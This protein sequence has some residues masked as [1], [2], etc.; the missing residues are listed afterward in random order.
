MALFDHMRKH[1]QDLSPSQKKLADY[2]ME[3]SR[4]AVFLNVQTLAETLDVDPATVTR[5][6]QRLGYS[7][8]R[9]LL[10]EL[11][12]MIQVELG[13]PLERVEVSREVQAIVAHILDKELH[14]LKEA[15]SPTQME[16][17]E[18]VIH[19]LEGAKRIFVLAHGRDAGFAQVF[20]HVLT[21]ALGTP[22]H[23]VPSDVLHGMFG[24]HDLGPGDVVVGLCLGSAGGDTGA[25][26][27]LAKSQGAKS[28]ALVPSPASSLA[29]KAD[30]ALFCPT[31]SLTRASSFVALA[32]VL[33]ALFQ[34]LALRNWE[35]YSERGAQMLQT[36]NFLLAK[37][38]STTMAVD[39][40]VPPKGNPV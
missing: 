19:S 13:L 39:D 12:E 3:N 8:Y 14:N 38:I 2:I 20:V 21:A 22:A 30:L 9:Q 6:A 23:F 28:I 18:A 33:W 35:G 34:A 27:D 36:A 25:F 15:L 32:A 5:F 4:E 26:L 7:G 17:F 29:Q 40:I 24:L 1:Y 31:D 37:R 16:A 11:R 10:A